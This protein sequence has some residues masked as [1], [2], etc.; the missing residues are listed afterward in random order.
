M[1]YM[2]LILHLCTEYTLPSPLPWRRKNSC[3]LPDQVATRDTD[4]Y[5]ISFLSFVF[6]SPIGLCSVVVLYCVSV[7]HRITSLLLPEDPGQVDSALGTGRVSLET[8]YSIF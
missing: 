8:F 2:R 7:S 3:V 5:Q 1:N 6:H 4:R